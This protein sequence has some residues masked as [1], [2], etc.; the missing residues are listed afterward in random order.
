MFTR[1]VECHAKPGKRDEFGNKLRNEVVP[2]LQK[3]AGFV[4]VIGLTSE[5]DADRMLAISFWKSKEDAERY[6]HEHYHRIVDI[7]KP[8]VKED[9]RVKTFNVETSTSQ[10]IA[11]RKAA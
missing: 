2:I 11:A 8:L 3:Q 1:I 6:E 9:P 10:R 5:D 4:D 7:I